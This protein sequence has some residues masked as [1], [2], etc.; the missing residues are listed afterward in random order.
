MGEGVGAQV[1]SVCQL[2]MHSIGLS[3]IRSR[4]SQADVLETAPQ[5][6][7]QTLGSL[8]LPAYVICMSCST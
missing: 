7:A 2:Q 8:L 1:A 3:R 5:V 6:V 4:D